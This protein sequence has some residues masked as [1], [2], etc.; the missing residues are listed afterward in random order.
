MPVNRKNSYYQSKTNLLE[1][2][3]KVTAIT[4]KKEKPK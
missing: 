4:R 3:I 1:G 2:R